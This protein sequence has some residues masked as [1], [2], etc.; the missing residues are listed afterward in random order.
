[1]IVESQ[2]FIFLPLTWD[3]WVIRGETQTC[4]I[5]EYF[6]DVLWTHRVQDRV[7]GLGRARRRNR[8]QKEVSVFP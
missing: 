3:A 5:D 8:T 4:H 7:P 6:K 1:M 2:Y